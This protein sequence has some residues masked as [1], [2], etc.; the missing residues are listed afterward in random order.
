[1]HCTFFGK[2]LG[3]GIRINFISD[4]LYSFASFPSTFKGQQV[5]FTSLKLLKQSVCQIDTANVE[6]R[7]PVNKSNTI[8]LRYH[9]PKAIEANS[10]IVF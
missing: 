3:G 9:R 8:T 10:T 1:M 5:E 7:F 6:N 4:Q 2:A